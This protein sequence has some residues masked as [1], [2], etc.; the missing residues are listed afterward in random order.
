MKSC[1]YCTE[2]TERL[3]ETDSGP[4]PVCAKC[5]ALLSS[6]RTGPRLIR[7]HMSLRLRGTMRPERLEEIFARG[8]PVLESMRKPA[9]D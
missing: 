3:I 6:P 5:S 2:E 4:V 9:A 7:G 1:D 8:M